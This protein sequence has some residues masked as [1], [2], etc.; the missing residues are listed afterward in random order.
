MSQQNNKNQGKP[1]KITTGT[2][3]L[4]ACIACVFFIAILIGAY[5]H[6]KR[7]NLLL[8]LQYKL[9]KYD[10]FIDRK[11]CMEKKN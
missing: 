9:D 1:I 7:L 6:I 8:K 11:N 5:I 4:I 2:Y 10:Y 3:I